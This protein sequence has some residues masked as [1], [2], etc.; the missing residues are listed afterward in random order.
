MNY[1]VCDKCGEFVT[2]TGVISS[3]PSLSKDA[4]CFG[5]CRN[6]DC[7]KHFSR[8]EYDKLKAEEF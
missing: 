7:N 3:L 6:K 1:K 5:K 8:S 4:G 2:K